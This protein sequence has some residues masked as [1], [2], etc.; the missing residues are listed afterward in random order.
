MTSDIELKCANLR[1]KL[2]SLRRVAVAFS[3]GADSAFLLKFAH[4]A[5]KSNVVAIIVKLIG[6]PVGDVEFAAEFCKANSIDYKILEFDEF[7][8]EGFAENTK[9]RCY[10]CK[11]A[12]FS[13]IINE[14]KS[15]GF[16]QVVDGTNYDDLFDFR[17]G[18]RALRELS[19]TSPLAE[20]KFSKKDILELLKEMGLKDVAQRQSSA[21]LSSR[22]PLGTKITKEKLSV[23]KEGEQLLSKIGFNR[24]RVR[25]YGEVAVIETGEEGFAL[26]IRKKQEIVVAIKALGFKRVVI[27]LEGYRTGSTNEKLEVDA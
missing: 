4:D 13:K 17:P 5:L 25:H 1:E 22:V 8:I 20:G 10:I 21:C 3:G 12:L 18:L 9:E 16:D 7:A 24:I 6:S 2:K 19:V 15:Q 14:A 27:D 26:A 11:L 23:I